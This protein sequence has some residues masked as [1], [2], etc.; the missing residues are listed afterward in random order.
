[1]VSI[2][3]CG[4]LG[5]PLAQSFIAEG[6]KI[7]GSTTKPQKLDILSANKIDPYLIQLADIRHNSNL[8]NFLSS[9]LLIIN[10]PPSRDFNTVDDYL[11]SLTLLNQYIE[12][13]A[14]KNLIFISSTSV[15]SYAVQEIDENGAIEESGLGQK[16]F[17]AEQIF[18]TNKHLNTTVIRMAGLF[19]PNRL[20][21][22]F[23][24]GKASVANGLA[25]VNM[26]HLDDCVAIIKKVVAL[27]YWNQTINACTPH[28]PSRKE[29][30]TEAIR[31]YG[32]TIPEFVEENGQYKLISPK[33]LITEL[34]YR[35]IHADLIHS[36]SSLAH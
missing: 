1:M 26:I 25:P 34:D 28:H 21:G 30:Y 33:K 5:L 12:N 9:K 15:Y 22:R 31:L 13:S 19:G 16:L 8:D 24:A 11:K 35:F 2:L 17:L 6:I 23:F 3:G 7:K 27:E 32:G 10:V 18:R 14:V 4:W 29:F 20:P 36:L